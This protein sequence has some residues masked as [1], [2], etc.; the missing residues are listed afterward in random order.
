LPRPGPAAGQGARHHQPET[1]QGKKERPD[2]HEIFLDGED[3][4]VRGRVTRGQV[5]GPCLP[6]P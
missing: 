3:Q 5:E 4:S 1:G 6:E 2:S